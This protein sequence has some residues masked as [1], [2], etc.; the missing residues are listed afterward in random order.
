MNPKI[1][2]KQRIPK[3]VEDDNMLIFLAMSEAVAG[4]DDNIFEGFPILFIG[5]VVLDCGKSGDG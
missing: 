3:A 2:E 5:A 4:S 1:S